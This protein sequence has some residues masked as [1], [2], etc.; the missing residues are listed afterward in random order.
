M[1]R[2]RVMEAAPWQ[3]DQMN[4]R[5]GKIYHSDPSDGDFVTHLDRMLRTFLGVC[6]GGTKVESENRRVVNA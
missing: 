6:H 2:S 1:K 5:V 4:M 3:L